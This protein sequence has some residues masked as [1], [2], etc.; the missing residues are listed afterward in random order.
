[1]GGLDVP[2]NPYIRNVNSGSQELM[3]SL[4]MKDVSNMGFPIASEEIIFSMAGVF[5]TISNVP[6][7]IGYT[8]YYKEHIL[9]SLGRMVKSVAINGVYPNKENISNKSYPYVAEVYVVIRSDLDKSSQAYKVYEFLQAEKGKQ[10]IRES[11]Y[12]TD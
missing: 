7:G 10:V 3:E 4:D 12:L 11:G 5:E 1:V 2:I 6:Y 8:V 9:S